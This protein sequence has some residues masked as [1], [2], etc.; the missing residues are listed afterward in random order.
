MVRAGLINFSKPLTNKLFDKTANE[1]KQREKYEDELMWWRVRFPDQSS[2]TMFVDTLMSLSK[3]GRVPSV[4]LCIRQF[5]DIHFLYVGL[6]IKV[7]LLFF[8]LEK[9]GIQLGRVAQHPSMM[10]HPFVRLKNDTVR[11]KKEDICIVNGQAWVSSKVH[12]GKSRVYWPRPNDV[13]VELESKSIIRSDFSHLGIAIA[14]TMPELGSDLQGTFPLNENH[15]ID[16]GCITG[17]SENNVRVLLNIL[18][19]G[20][21]PAVVLDMDNSVASK[22]ER[23]DSI[24]RLSEMGQIR[25]LDI[26]LAGQGGLSPFVIGE[27]TS[28]AVDW[29][30]FWLTNMGIRPISV[31]E[32][33]LKYMKEHNDPNKV[34][35]WKS[36]WATVNHLLAKKDLR[37]QHAELFRRAFEPLS[38]NPD[39]AQ[40]LTVNPIQVDSEKDVFIVHGSKRINEKIKHI[41]FLSSIVCGAIH[42]MPLVLVGR[43]NFTVKEIERII[44]RY[45]APILLVGMAYP[46]GAFVAT[47]SSEERARKSARQMKEVFPKRNDNGLVLAEYISSLR[48]K[49]CFV[50][51]NDQMGV[52]KYDGA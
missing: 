27:S 1:K 32:P 29:W 25:M 21:T 19:W 48:T 6:P 12:E 2:C 9:K 26:E 49:Q 23:T 11:S 34:M 36:A 17:D 38:T 8:S 37:P 46:F 7:D 39:L 50:L 4:L 20:S 40:W 14:P 52:V 5:K 24:K 16:N 31:V 41:C 13:D 43:G 51:T 33:V 3:S 28:G 44:K 15:S 22:A 35:T 10:E 47:R 18:S 42:K 30:R 45:P